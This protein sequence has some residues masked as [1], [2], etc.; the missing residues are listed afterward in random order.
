MA[1]A[2]TPQARK[3]ATAQ[4]E[5]RLNP[6][7]AQEGPRRASRAPEDRPPRPNRRPR[8]SAGTSS[9]SDR[10]HP[11]HLRAVLSPD[12]LKMLE[13]LSANL[14]RAAVTAQG[15]IAEAACARPTARPP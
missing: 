1:T 4:G 5:P 13:K 9:A 10:P 8:P 15:A 6:S 2:K 7:Q 3:K 12:Q 14:A 11:S